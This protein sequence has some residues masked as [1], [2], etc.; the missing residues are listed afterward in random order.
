[1]ENIMSIKHPDFIEFEIGTYC[2][3]TCSW[4][5]NALNSRGH[6]KNHVAPALWR[7][8]LQDLAT[9]HYQGILAIHNYNEPLLD[10]YVFDRIKDAREIAPEAKLV[11]FTNGDPLNTVVL[12]ELKALSIHEL[13]ITLYPKENRE[14]VL[15]PYALDKLFKRISMS[16]GDFTLTLTDR[17][18]EY[19]GKQDNL[20]FFII[21]PIVENYTNR[22]GSLNMS[23]MVVR[24]EPC[25]LPEHSVAIDYLGN[26]K[27]CCQVQDV[28]NDDVYNIGNIATEGFFSVW[29]G[30]KLNTIRAK[31][32]DSDFSM[33]KYCSECDHSKDYSPALAA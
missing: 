17:G 19:E 18:L 31:L 9:E 2:N 27:L 21:V 20:N 3:R 8:F 10:P 4:C 11:V 22:A 24:T 5:P 23:K 16:E 33:L 26:F 25:Y 30:Y 29:K 12:D 6:E 7:N 15:T 28:L 13:R 1:M 14:G 32:R